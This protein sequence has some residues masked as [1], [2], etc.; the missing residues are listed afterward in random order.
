M[1][2][3]GE[4]VIKVIAGIAVDLE[5]GKRY[6]ACVPR[7]AIGEHNE[8]YDIVITELLDEKPIAIIN[9]VDMLWAEKFVREFNTDGI[10]GRIF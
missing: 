8:E 3:D 2:L 4:G 1:E 7:I 10:K 6:L 9:S 5:E